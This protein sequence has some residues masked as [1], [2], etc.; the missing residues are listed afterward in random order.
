MVALMH[1]PSQGKSAWHLRNTAHTASGGLLRSDQ[2]CS[3]LKDCW[4]SRLLAQL[5]P[6]LKPVQCL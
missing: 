6:A 4:P 2:S 1:L 3:Y 5:L